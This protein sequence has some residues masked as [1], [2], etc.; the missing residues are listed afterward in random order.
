VSHDGIRSS[1]GDLILAN[2]NTVAFPAMFEIDAVVGTKINIL[3]SPDI[4]LSGSNGGA[5]TLKLGAPDKGY[6]FT[7]TAVSTQRTAINFGGTL[8]IGTSQG[9]PGGDYSGIF[10]V[11]FIVIEE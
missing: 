7:T 10:S 9:N 8:T 11:T 4:Q 1:T 5:I 6:N 2:L 3:S